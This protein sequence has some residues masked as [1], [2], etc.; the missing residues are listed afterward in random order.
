M[1]IKDNYIEK[2]S[3]E[4]SELVLRTKNKLNKKC[5]FLDRDGVIIE[6]V[7]YINK[8]SRIKLCCNVI[9]FLAFAVENNFDIVIVTNQSSVSRKIISYEKYYEITESILSKLPCNFYPKYILASFHL[10]N[11]ENKL[12]NFNWRK[13]GTGMFEY[14][15]KNQKYNK[16][17][18]YMIGD[19]LSDLI[20]AF[21]CNI[22][23]L[24]FLP[25]SSHL[26]EIP[27]VKEWNKINSNAI[28][29]IK[30]L[31]PK[32]LKS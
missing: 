18:S 17:D 29:F 20:P 6:D 28:K 26:D 3:R 12:D 9:P 8:V 30:F 5:L 2:F 31:D 25:S 7:K 22:G 1:I 24:L 10:P 15:F 32:Y 11:N 16:K 19:K 27:K 14:T 13:P 23:R 4:K 21:E